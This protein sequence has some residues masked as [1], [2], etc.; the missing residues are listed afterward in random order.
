MTS[1]TYN[2]GRE[3]KKQMKRIRHKQCPICGKPWKEVEDS[4]AKKKTGHVFKMTCKCAPDNVQ[5]SF[6]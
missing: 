1:P 2:A 5:I 3:E 6:G 4:I